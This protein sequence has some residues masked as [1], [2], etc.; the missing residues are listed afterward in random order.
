MGRALQPEILSSGILT[1]Q[2]LGLEI[3]PTDGIGPFAD[4]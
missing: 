1:H 3:A 4:S 2:L